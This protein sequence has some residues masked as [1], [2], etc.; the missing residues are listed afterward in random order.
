MS[1]CENENIYLWNGFWTD[2]N[3]TQ[4]KLIIYYSSINEMISTSEFTV[5]F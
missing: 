3:R 5:A 4:I 1:K 2:E